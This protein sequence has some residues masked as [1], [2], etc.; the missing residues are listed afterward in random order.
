MTTTFTLSTSRRDA[1]KI[2]SLVVAGGAA[3]IGST[4]AIAPSAAA[5][6]RLDTGV[7]LG[8]G[9]VGTRTVVLDQPSVRAEALAAVRQLRLDMWAKNPPLLSVDG[10]TGGTVQSY[11]QEQGYASAEAYADALVWDQDMERVSVQRLVECL[12]MGRIEHSRPN[13][14]SYSTAHIGDVTNGTFEILAAT[15]DQSATIST[16]IGIWASEYDKLVAA[17][18]AWN[19]ETGHLHTLLNPTITSIG[20]A[21]SAGY[22]TGEGLWTHSA[23]AES[24][25][26]SG[27]YD[28]TLANGGGSASSV[29]AGY[30]APAPAASELAS[31]SASAAPTPADPTT[32]TNRLRPAVTKPWDLSSSGSS[33]DSLLRGLRAVF[34]GK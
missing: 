3:L 11:A 2:G 24:V 13:G 7:H 30:Q 21:A 26:W 10:S 17:G 18:G 20:F 14:E 12:E 15:T 8:S 34:R 16:G 29:P 32:A 33:P 23:P 25:G 27:I 9:S 19:H 5:S 1:L 22:F 28:V 6:S 31:A 4:A